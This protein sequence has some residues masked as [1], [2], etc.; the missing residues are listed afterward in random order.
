ML[1]LDSKSSLL[2]QS[3]S[4]DVHNCLRGTTVACFAF[5]SLLCAFLCIPHVAATPGVRS[6]SSTINESLGS[7]PSYH[8]PQIVGPRA[9]SV[10]ELSTLLVDLAAESSLGSST[11]TGTEEL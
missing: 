10:S 7:A 1:R 6:S 4:S 5:L 2:S 11:L 3:R 8:L 9:E